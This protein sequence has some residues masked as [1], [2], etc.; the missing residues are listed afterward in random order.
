[1]NSGLAGEAP[2]PELTWATFCQATQR[3]GHGYRE[4]GLET[5]SV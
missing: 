5:H 2:A 4:P 1:M 3:S